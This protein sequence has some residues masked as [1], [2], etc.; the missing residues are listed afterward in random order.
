M[1]STPHL[2]PRLPHPRSRPTRN[3]WPYDYD[4]GCVSRELLTLLLP[5]AAFAGTRTEAASISRALRES[6]VMPP[7]RPTVSRS[8][9]EHFEFPPG[10]SHGVR[11]SHH[12]ASMGGNAPPA[13]GPR[14]AEHMTLPLRA[15]RVQICTRAHAA[16]TYTRPGHLVVSMHVSPD[17]CLFA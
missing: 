15:E 14:A 2:R 11:L 1:R 17:E 7:H 3:A 9:W 8:A 5:S 12:P 10:G 4:P 13:I 6:C 16:G